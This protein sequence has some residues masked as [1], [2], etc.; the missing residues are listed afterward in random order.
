MYDS[1]VSLSWIFV[2]LA[3]D[4]TKVRGPHIQRKQENNFNFENFKNI[5]GKD[6]NETIQKLTKY[7]D[8][9]LS[10]I[11]FGSSRR[12]YELDND[13]VLKVAYNEA[14]IAQN[15]M[16][17][18]IQNDSE[19]FADVYDMHPGA[20]WIVA[21][22]IGEIDP[23]TFEVITGISQSLMIRI[24][25]NLDTRLGVVRITPEIAR[26][27][28]HRFNIGQKGIKFLNDISKLRGKFDLI[29]GDTFNPKHWGINADGKIKLYDFGLDS[30]VYDN[31]YHDNGFL[32]TDPTYG[33]NNPDQS[34]IDALKLMNSNT[35]VY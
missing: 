18:K 30:S 12:V 33:P 8:L 4:I 14:G 23:N 15:F 16:E 26:E 7:A 31:F 1:I 21:E 29:F 2:K 24:N 22:K 11:N 28:S 6:N 3:D 17:A 13:R 25:Q 34:K 20:L 5:Q 32:R 10:L 35:A 27:L 9:H 19:Y